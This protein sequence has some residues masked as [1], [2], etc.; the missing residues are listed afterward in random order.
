MGT[1]SVPRVGR[2][3]Q[4]E[5]HEIILLCYAQH[6]GRVWEAF[7]LD[8]DLAVQGQSLHEATASLQSAIGDYID[9][10]MEEEE[11]TRTQLLNRRAPLHLRLLWTWRIVRAITFGRKR[12]GDSAVGFPVTCPAG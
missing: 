8:F 3:H 9:A 7:C 6:D 10:A 1:S 2:D 11:P 4:E 5:N 12:D